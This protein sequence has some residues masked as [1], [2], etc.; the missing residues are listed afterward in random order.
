MDD[1]EEPV[2]TKLHEDLPPAPSSPSI[3]EEMHKSH[4]IH[5]NSVDMEGGKYSLFTLNKN[6]MNFNFL[7]RQRLEHGR[8]SPQKQ[9]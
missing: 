3:N 9:R 7:C 6:F 5:E 2:D 4:S 8:S 1:Q